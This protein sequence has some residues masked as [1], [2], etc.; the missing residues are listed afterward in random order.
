MAIM[1]STT[2]QSLY[3]FQINWPIEF[4]IKT[5]HLLVGVNSASNF[6]I[7]LLLR[8]NFRAA[9]WRL[10][11]CNK[12]P[13]DDRSVSVMARSQTMR[14]ATTRLSQVGKTL[15]GHQIQSDHSDH[16]THSNSC[17]MTEIWDVPPA[18]LL[19]H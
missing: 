2:S 5:S 15:H 14:T 1:K 10:L 11:T 6:F 8:K 18:V 16:S 19:S 9:T 12:P 13:A 4:I 3:F 17:C 7:Y